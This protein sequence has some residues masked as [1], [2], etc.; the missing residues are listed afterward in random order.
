MRTT[1]IAVQTT[2]DIELE[3]ENIIGE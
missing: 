3:Y 2:I 1:A